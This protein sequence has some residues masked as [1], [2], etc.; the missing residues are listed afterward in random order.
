V[1][2]DKRYGWRLVAAT[3]ALALI[4]SACGDGG[5]T[6][7][8]DPGTASDGEEDG[9]DEQADAPPG[10][11][12]CEEGGDAPVRWAHEQEPSDLHLD[13][14]ANNL[15]ITSWIQQGMLE[16]LYGVSA[17]TEFVPELLAEEGE[18]TE[19]DDGTFTFSFVL[20]DDIQWSDGEPI[21]AETVKGTFDIFMEG[22]DFEADSAED[23]V[24]ALSSRQGYDLIDPDSWE[25]DGQTFSYTMDS[26]FA[27]WPSIFARLLPVHV[28]PDAAAANE[29]LREFQ[30]DGEPLPASGPFQ[31]SEWNRGVSMSLTANADYHGGNPLNEEIINENA[32]C[33]SGVE[34][35]WVT[36]TDAQV[37][38]LRAGE[39]DFI[40]TQPQVQFGE[41]L[42]DD[43]QF[44]LASEAGPSFEHWSLNLNNEHLADPNVREALAYAMDKSVVMESLYVPLFQDVLPVEGLGNTYW[45]T[46]SPN[47][48]D[49][50]GDAGY[51]QG[52][53]ESA[54]ALL[55]ESGYSDDGGTW[56]HPD[57]GPLSLRVSTTGGNQLRELQQQLLQAQLNDAGWD[58]TIDNAPGAEHFS[59]Q[60]FSPEA[61]ACSISGGDEGATVSLSSGDD[62]T[63][64][65][66]VFDISQ[67][68]W[69]GGPWPGGQNVAYLS[70]SENNPHGYA[71]EE[72]DTLLA[73][74]GETVDDDE[75]ATCYNE[76]DRYVTT[77]EVDDN[78]LVI[79]PLTQKPQFYAYSNN[80]LAA[81][82]VAPDANDAGPLT[83][84]V[85]FLPAG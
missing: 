70:G 85:D 56:E 12:Y 79:I 54:A 43:P 15:S 33:V 76:A 40:F 64:D 82:A 63:A 78:G 67:F 58:I 75:R 14:P 81:G 32:P 25:V 21:T 80:T 4:A 20:R 24:Y 47:Y 38:A 31:F 39:A 10:D 65:C 62:A 57:R 77:R 37:N 59:E 46:N 60:V 26:F 29:A 1:A 84:G 27:G 51:G 16:G 36:D 50:A 41:G 53:T 7:T 73:E 5:D 71:N 35:T 52:D 3:S 11:A 55:E 68:A 61:T 66:G 72:L 69:V 44:T 17:T 45:Y 22:Y 49:H 42:A 6:S 18:V 74:C 8:D 34:I 23:A 83:Y 28:L 30:V 19:N 48:E 13:D 2:R 9:G